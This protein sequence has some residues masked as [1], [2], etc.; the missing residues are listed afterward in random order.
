LACSLAETLPW[1]LPG[2]ASHQRLDRPSDER[3]N[4]PILDG[5]SA[6]PAQIAARVKQARFAHGGCLLATIPIEQGF[7]GGGGEAKSTF[8]ELSRFFARSVRLVV[9]LC[10]PCASGLALVETRLIIATSR[11]TGDN[12]RCPVG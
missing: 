10:R 1:Y 9:A 2:R 5:E 3:S 12:S 6:T 4:A 8:L 7:E 11:T